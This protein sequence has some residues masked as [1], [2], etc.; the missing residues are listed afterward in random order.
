MDMNR[1]TRRRTKRIVIAVI[2]C[3]GILWLYT[4]HS[5][6]SLPDISHLRAAPPDKTAFM[7]DYD[8]DRK[9]RYS[10]VPMKRLSRHLQH[11]VVIAEDDQFWNHCGFNWGAIKAAAKRNWKKKSFS[12]GASTI[13]QQLARN[14]FLSRSKNPFRKVKELLIA[15]KMERELSKK[16]ILELYLNVVEW[17]DGIYGANAAA[18][19]YFGT[20]PAGLNTHQAAFLAAILPRP[21]Y[22]DKHRNGPYLQNRIDSIKRRL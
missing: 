16:R 20:S 15:L 22:Y 6:F 10:W 19:H 8:G 9:I 11:A 4:L 2:S 12:Y 7:D 14:L 13:T 5:M 18:R 21:R 3:L 1:K 17:G